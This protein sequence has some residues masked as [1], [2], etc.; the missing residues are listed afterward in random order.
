[1]NK[2]RKELNNIELK[3]AEGIESQWKGAKFIR[4]ETGYDDGS[5]CFVFYIPDSEKGKWD[6]YGKALQ[7]ANEVYS[8][9]DD[10]PL[11]ISTGKLSEIKE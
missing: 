4:L 9:S 3:A 10:Q 6:F 11:L 8:Y 2:Y 5:I 7:I 1:M